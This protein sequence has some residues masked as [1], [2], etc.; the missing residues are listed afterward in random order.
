MTG[1]V[2]DSSPIQNTPRG[3]AY[4]PTSSASNGAAT[5]PMMD[6]EAFKQAAEQSKK[7][8]V[9]RDLLNK[10]N[11][12]SA[13][14]EEIARYAELV[15]TTPDR[16]AQPPAQIVNSTKQVVDWDRFTSDK[17]YAKLIHAKVEYYTCKTELLGLEEKHDQLKMKRMEEVMKLQA[18]IIAKTAAGEKVDINPADLS[19]DINTKELEEELT[20]RLNTAKDTIDQLDLLDIRLETSSSVARASRIV[21]RPA[22]V[23][24]DL[25]YG[26]PQVKISS[27]NLSGMESRGG[28]KKAIP[29]S[30]NSLKRSTSME[31][32]PRVNA[33]NKRYS[34]QGVSDTSKQDVFKLQEQ[35]LREQEAQDRE[36]H[37]TSS[38]IIQ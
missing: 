27:A 38:D 15:G 7:A 36:F 37:S 21:E 13:T 22:A 16:V 18:E 30:A 28:V 29:G 1:S 5:K 10:I 12:N 8:I 33:S 20:R 31:G 11:A 9:A 24:P 23:M 32:P 25:G 14:S 26:T 17:K 35:M 6:A 4:M 19:L 34:T 2:F 3:N